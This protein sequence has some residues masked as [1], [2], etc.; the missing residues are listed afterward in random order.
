MGLGMSGGMSVSPAYAIRGESGCNDGRAVV[1]RRVRNVSASLKAF[2]CASASIGGVLSG[3]GLAS[4]GW[5]AASAGMSETLTLVSYAAYA[6]AMP[7]GAAILGPPAM[8]IAYRSIVRTVTGRVPHLWDAVRM[9]VR[10]V[11]HGIADIRRG[12]EIVPSEYDNAAVL[13]NGSYVLSG[14]AETRIYNDTVTEIIPLPFVYDKADDLRDKIR[15]FGP[16]LYAVCLPGQ[17]DVVRKW[18]VVDGTGKTVMETSAEA[19]RVLS[20]ARIMFSAGSEA[21]IYDTKGDLVA[22]FNPRRLNL[23]ELYGNDTMRV[24]DTALNRQEV[25]DSRG[26]TMRVISGQEAVA[27]L[28]EVANPRMSGSERAVEKLLE[29]EVESRGGTTARGGR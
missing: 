17:Y 21:K 20:D 24:H 8:K 5:L 1:S 15:P 27:G 12:V 29:N 25:I 9:D 18:Q 26:H 16:A 13:G 23:L 19:M 10:D 3:L 2:A 4:W 22:S 11:K 6:V 28:A 7:F 14:P